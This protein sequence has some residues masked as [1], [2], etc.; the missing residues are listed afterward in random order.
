MNSPISLGPP[1]RPGPQR[2]LTSRATRPAFR[3]TTPHPP[4]AAALADRAPAR[5][6]T[7]TAGRAGNSRP[8]RPRTPATLVLSARWIRVVWPCGTFGHPRA[9]FVA[10]AGFMLSPLPQFCSFPHNAQLGWT[11]GDD[12]AVLCAGHRPMALLPVLRLQA[13]QEPTRS[14]RLIQ[15]SRRRCSVRAP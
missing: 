2:R 8:G 14:L 5:R 7:R 3:R 13:L 4:P 1:N 10:L 12:V 6:H 9:W 11:P 15:S